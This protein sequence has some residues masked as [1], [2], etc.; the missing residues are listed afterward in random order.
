MDRE[1]PRH[2]PA[3]DRHAVPPQSVD[4]HIVVEDEF[5]PSEDYVGV[6]EVGR[7]DDAVTVLGSEYRVSQS[8]VDRAV[9]VGPPDGQGGRHLTGLQ[10]LEGGPEAG[11]C[12]SSA[13][14]SWF[15]PVSE[16]HG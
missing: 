11:P 2:V 7:D 5:P 13:V 14:C 3:A 1:H 10:T 6:L 12:D 16:K 4:S 15:Q 8:A 9:V